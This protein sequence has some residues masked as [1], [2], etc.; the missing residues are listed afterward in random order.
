R[1]RGAACPVERRE[2][3]LHLLHARRRP[4]LRGRAAPGHERVPGVLPR[5]AR[6]GRV[7]AAERVRGVVRVGGAGRRGPGGHRG[8]PAGGG[9]SS[10]GVVMTTTTVV[11]LLRH[12]EVYNPDKVLYGRLPGYR[13]SE[14]GVQMAKA[15][16][17]ALAGHDGAH[18]VA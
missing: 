10:G 7:P 15:A 17:E 14:L 1:R 18:V 12:G 3:V 5:D 9:T 13:L 16:A 2:H 4:R 6:P 8:G 11:H